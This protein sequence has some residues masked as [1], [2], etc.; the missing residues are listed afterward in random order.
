MEAV[1]GRK[2]QLLDDVGNGRLAGA[3][4]AGE[5]E[6]G[7][8]RFFSAARSLLPA[9]SARQLEVAR[10]RQTLSFGAPTFR[11]EIIEPGT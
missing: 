2:A 1:A 3:R 7:R 5:P 10:R 9:K 6:N 4:Q 8:L 11:F